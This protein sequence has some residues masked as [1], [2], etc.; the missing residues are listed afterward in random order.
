MRWN[1]EIS[2]P[3]KAKCLHNLLRK[4][5]KY[6]ALNLMVIVMSIQPKEG[7]VTSGGFRLHYLQWGQGGPPL[8]ILPSMGMDAHA[9]DAFSRA[10]SGEHRVLAFDLLDHGDSEKLT[11]P[12]GQEEHAEVVRGAYRQL[13][14]SPNVLIGH[15]IGG[16]LGMILAAKHPDELKGLVLVDI[17]PFDPTQL[18][19]AP[20]M[21]PPESFAD[22]DEAGRY[23]RQ[24]YPG[25]TQEAVENRMRY[26][27]TKSPDGGLRF[28]GIGNTLRGGIRAD[29]WPFV[30]RIRTPTLL[31][32][33]GEGR[34]V[35]AGALE[36]MRSLIPD[37]TAVTVEG[38]THMIPQDRPAAFERE[39]RAFLA[40][41]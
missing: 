23:I 26:A 20:P 16:M 8:V 2:I 39:V 38:A 19:R 7:F 3:H 33:A 41:I 34:I 5:L 35:T 32:V 40:R 21:E 18:R 1:N 12:V 27:F 17:V 22:E 9:Y 37:F 6:P 11:R 10:V 36:R 24:R 30:E 31:L 25:F 13:G 15:S 28:K 29:L 4:V 14:F